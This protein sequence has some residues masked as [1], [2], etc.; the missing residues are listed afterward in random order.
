MLESQLKK[1]GWLP[2]SQ[3]LFVDPALPPHK[4]RKARP[5]YHWF[6]KEIS[7]TWVEKKNGE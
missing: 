1:D 6:W 2:D 7:G 3:D 4:E 5:G